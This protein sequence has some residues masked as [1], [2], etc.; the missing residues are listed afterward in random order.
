[1]PGSDKTSYE[2]FIA[3]EGGKR[4]SPEDSEKAVN[5]SLKK[6]EALMAMAAAKE[7]EDELKQEY[8][9]QLISEKK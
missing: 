5:E 7:R 9:I 3:Y 1:L 6:A 4:L 8:F 2:R